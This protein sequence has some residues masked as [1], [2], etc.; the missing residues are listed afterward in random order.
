MIA[1]IRKAVAAFAG[2][3]LPALAYAQAGGLTVEEVGGAVALALAAAWAVWR[4]PNR[5]A[6]A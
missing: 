3:L 2:S 6:I 4:V 5:D 1:R